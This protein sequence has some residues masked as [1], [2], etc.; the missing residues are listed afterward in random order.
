MVDADENDLDSV[1]DEFN[2]WR[3]MIDLATGPE[4]KKK[5]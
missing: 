1:A 5:A 4:N 3:K 2:Y